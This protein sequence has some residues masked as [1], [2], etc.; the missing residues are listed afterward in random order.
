MLIKKSLKSLALFLFPMCTTRRASALTSNEATYFF[1]KSKA[2]SFCEKILN[3]GKVYSYSS[4]YY[5]S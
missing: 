1:M 4:Y 2:N 5:Y 3:N